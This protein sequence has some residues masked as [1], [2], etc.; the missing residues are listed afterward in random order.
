MMEPPLDY[1]EII[2]EEAQIEIKELPANDLSKP[3]FVE[4]EWPGMEDNDTEHCKIP[5][6]ARLFNNISGVSNMNNPEFESSD[7]ENPGCNIES[8]RC[9]A[10]PKL[11]KA[12]V[13][14]DDTV[15]SFITDSLEILAD[16][17]VPSAMVVL[18]GMLAERPNESNLGIGTTIG[19]IV[20]RL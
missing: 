9:L 12:F 1:Y 15:L 8:I 18:G 3:P 20:A 14:G 4:A 10:E 16:E 5:F 17:M 11:L 13:F 19:I 7:H 2:E 6:I